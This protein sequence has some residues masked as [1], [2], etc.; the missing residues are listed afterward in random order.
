MSVDDP[1]SQS[2]WDND[3]VT[4]NTDGM[5]DAPEQKWRMDHA[6]T[7]FSIALVMR[8]SNGEAGVRGGSQ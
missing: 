7:A 5:F 4:L 8:L 1:P 2:Y 6:P 3:G